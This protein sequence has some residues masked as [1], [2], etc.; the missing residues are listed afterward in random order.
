MDSVYHFSTDICTSNC[1]YLQDLYSDSTAIKALFL[2]L[3][4]WRS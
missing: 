3:N 4:Q 2:Y 1:I